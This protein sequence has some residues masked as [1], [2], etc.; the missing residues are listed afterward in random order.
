MILII[1]C[2]FLVEF[3]AGARIF[4]CPVSDVK[5]EK[6]LGLRPPNISN[7]LL[8]FQLNENA[9]QR[10]IT[11]DCI[12]NDDSLETYESE[13]VIDENA[14]WFIKSCYLI[15]K[16]CDK[17]WV[18]ER[19]PGAI[20]V[21]NDAK[22]LPG[23][24][25]RSDCQQYCL[26]ETEFLCR[27]VK[28]RISKSNHRQDM[29]IQGTCTLSNVDRHQLPSSYRVSGYDDEYLENQCAI[30]NNQNI[31]GEFC[32]YEEYA[33]VTLEH[34]DI[35]FQ[36]KSKVECQ[37]L[38]ETFKT[39][40]CRAFSIINSNL[41]YL[42]SEDSKIFGPTLLRKWQNSTY[43]EK[44]SCLN[45]SVSCSETYMSIRYD[46]EMDFF[47]KL[48]MLGYSE[49]PPCY[50]IGR[51]KLQII[52]LNI[53]LFLDRCG[54][55]KAEDPLN[56]T[57]LTGTLLIQYNQIIQTQSDRLIR[58]GCIFANDS[59]LVIGT[60]VKISPMLP[61]N[62]SSLINPYFNA[63]TSPDIQMKIL[64]P[65]TGGEVSDSQIGQELQ[66]I[67]EL[68]SPH[69]LD[70]WA[71]HLIAMT[72]KNEESIF[73]LDDKGCPTNLNIFP[74]LEKVVTETST[75]LVASFQAFKFADSPIV[76][77]SVIIQFC[78]VECPPIQCGNN[79]LSY[80]RRKREIV[81]H[82]IHTINGTQIVKLN[83]SEFQ[84][85]SSVMYEMPLEYIMLVRDSKNGPE[86][87]VIGENNRILVAGYDF[88][89][90]EVC[91]DTL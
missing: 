61:S 42:H 44:A 60:G 28:F 64:D 11:L 3:N 31:N 39:F 8:L 91:M 66:L 84:E 67:I 45:I 2:L 79:I 55:I 47:G 37:N 86:R 69:N 23:T 30:Y 16:P 35:A 46:P 26:N 53:P 65:H 68:K 70:I 74:S 33:N 62:G 41:C 19:I 89:T 9:P 1:W 75:E 49:S 18:F 17:A 83:R 7:A 27:S 43:Y 15:E 58:V 77:F 90:D 4:S 52:T 6:V 57:L 72:E 13:Y 10:P 63:T 48:Y 14:A 82:K 50:S 24:H 81:S 25:T 21:G 34:S 40:H 78:S 56:R 59:R 80:G 88:V 22:T 71:S 51:G 73:L 29:D 38:C 85:K 32:A 20:L 5:F 12:T 76:R 54:I 36:E 87:L